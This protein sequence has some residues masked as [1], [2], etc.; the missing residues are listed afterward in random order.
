MVK[1]FGGKFQLDSSRQK[2]EMHKPIQWV[3]IA[4][5]NMGND[6]DDESMGE[7][8]ENFIQMKINETALSNCLSNVE[9]LTGQ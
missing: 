5:M 6:N 2:P 9:N 8:F 7:S 3:K 1:K 4:S